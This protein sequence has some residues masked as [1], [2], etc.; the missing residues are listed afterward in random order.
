MRLRWL[1][2]KRVGLN[3]RIKYLA[4]RLALQWYL[5]SI[6]KGK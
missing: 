5:S 6:G 2:V 1:D 3:F 4:R